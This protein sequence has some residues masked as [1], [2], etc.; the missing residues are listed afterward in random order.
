MSKAD[1]IQVIRAANGKIRS[2]TANRGYWLRR[3]I[4]SGFDLLM[5]TTSWLPESCSFGE[6]V[7][8]FENDCLERPKCICGNE[9]VKFDEGRYPTYCSI[10]C[11]GKSQAVREKRATTNFTRYGGTTPAASEAVRQK[12]RE[13]CLSQY[14]VAHL[15]KD[16]EYQKTK[17]QAYLK[18]TGRMCNRQLHIDD[19]AYQRLND[20]DWL[21]RR[22]HDDGISMY[23]M[24]IEL[25]VTYRTIRVVLDRYQIEKKLY[26]RGVGETQIGEYI[27]SLG[28]IAERKDRQII[29]P[30]EIDV[31]I[32]EKKLGIEYQGLHWHA[33][34][35]K[36][37]LVAKIERARL[38]GI[39]LM[40]IFENEWVSQK[41]QDIV[42]S[43]IASRCGMSSTTIGARN[44]VLQA[45]NRSD[46][47][48]F[49]WANHLQGA[50]PTFSHCLGLMNDGKWVAA[51]MFG[52][53][54]FAEGWELIRFA[55]A[56]NHSVP[57]GAS[58][59]FQ[60]FVREQQPAS[61]ISYADR[62]YSEGR[63]YAQLGFVFSHHS[64][65]NYWYFRE[66]S[67][68]KLYHRMGFQKHK[69]ANRLEKF[70]PGCTEWENMQ[71]NGWRR[72]WD[73]GNMVWHW[74]SC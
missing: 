72:I 22:H 66:N 4:E 46:A 55:A 73:A 1:I 47:M 8:V 60:A 58:R 33:S 52:S 68:Y 2:F 67:R 74:R 69:L 62:R 59:L 5:T 41:K 35:P 45:M 38:A 25:G 9:I 32:P 56:K 17:Q 40:V 12:A 43:M 50:P 42:R 27:Q 13:T 11:V 49:M 64:A 65:P 63:M 14:G 54:R 57:G 61:I 18:K 16:P 53:S 70:D 23:Q 29:A 10:R 44:C 51:M 6:R 36:G 26:Y 19:N 7:F 3:G 30:L 37:K 39:N 28:L 24:A 31:W 48:D 71:A 20:V 34:D 21:R 15:S